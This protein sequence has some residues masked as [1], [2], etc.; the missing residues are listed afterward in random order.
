MTKSTPAILYEV[1]DVRTDQLIGTITGTQLREAA[2]R[3]PQSPV[4][5]AELV[6]QFNENKTRIGEPERIRQAL[7]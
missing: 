4:F 3:L 1:Y 2:G 6:S 5:N 7:R